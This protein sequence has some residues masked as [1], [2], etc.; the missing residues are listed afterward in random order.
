[1]RWMMLQTI[2]YLWVGHLTAIEDVRQ[3]I[4]LRAYGQQD[5]LV[6][7]KREAFHMFGELIA[8]IRGD[9]VRRFFR[10]QI[11][12]P[13]QEETVLTRHRDSEAAL[14]ASNADRPTAVAQP[15]A[16]TNGAGQA[17]RLSRRERRARERARKKRARRR[18]RQRVH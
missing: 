1:M 9:I 13:V 14:P 16:A 8:S 7:F 10:V 11:Q 4:G 15:P 12:D 2:D 18:G 17:P 5:P 3:G 6:A